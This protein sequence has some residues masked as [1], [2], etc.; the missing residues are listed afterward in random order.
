[1]GRLFGVCIASFSL[2]G[3]A[4]A[5]K[6]RLVPRKYRGQE[7]RSLR[8][9]GR[10][11]YV[12]QLSTGNHQEQD[13]LSK[14]FVVREGLLYYCVSDQKWRGK[15][16]MDVKQ[17]ATAFW[18]HCYKHPIQIN[19]NPKA[20]NGYLTWEP[21]LSSPGYSFT[22]GQHE[23][24]D[25]CEKW[26]HLNWVRLKAPPP[27]TDPWHC[28]AKLINLGVVTTVLFCSSI[29]LSL[30]GNC[31]ALWNITVILFSIY[32]ITSDRISSPRYYFLGNIHTQHYY[33][34]GNIYANIS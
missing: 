7:I 19:R 33:F 32:C 21:V 31:V 27:H 1:L 12:P 2:A 5:E 22:D 14:M 24:C 16:D 8:L 11:M 18:I 17:H 34:L 13:A 3:Q 15:A 10:W 4:F 29:Q 25:G 20:Y 28:S 6:E 23:R 30:A 9:F 26:F